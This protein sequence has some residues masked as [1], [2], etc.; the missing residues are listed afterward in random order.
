MLR[1]G[2]FSFL[3]LFPAGDHADLFG[4]PQTVGQHHG[5]THHLIGVPGVHSQAQ[6]NFNRLVKLGRGQLLHQRKSRL[7]RVGL[8]LNLRSG[9][10]HA[11]TRLRHWDSSVTHFD[12]HAAGR[13]LDDGDRPGQIVGIEIRHFLLG[14]F[15]NLL[16]CDLAHLV[17]VGSTGSLGNS[18]Q[19][20]Q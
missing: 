3:L 12:S 6:R 13:S 11:L 7:Q 1:P 2:L 19:P 18:G 4:L 5:A 8:S 14:Y 10:G 20:F 9:P 16:L 17:S 15:L